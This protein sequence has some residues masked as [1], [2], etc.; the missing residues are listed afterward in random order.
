[1]AYP[2]ITTGL[3]HHQVST[4]QPMTPSAGLLIQEPLL[5]ASPADLYVSDDGHS[6]SCSH[7][8]LLRVLGVRDSLACQRL[9]YG[10]VGSISCYRRI[11]H[12]CL[13]VLYAV[14]LIFFSLFLLSWSM[15]EE[16]LY[17]ACGGYL[18]DLVEISL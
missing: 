14:P 8:G 16:C 10:C 5:H 12:L 18:V 17:A 11:S 3:Q 15:F 1:M 7:C 6:A 4:A 9:V 13:A 2:H